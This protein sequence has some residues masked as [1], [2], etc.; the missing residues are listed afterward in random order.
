MDID[1]PVYG[2]AGVLPVPEDEVH[3]VPG[4]GPGG[5]VAGQL[6]L[7]PLHGGHGVR[8]AGHGLAGHGGQDCKSSTSLFLPLSLLTPLPVL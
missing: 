2:S 7:A 5:D 1:L 6:G 3:A 8:R 4:P